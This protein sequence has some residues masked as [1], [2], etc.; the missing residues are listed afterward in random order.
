MR[1]LPARPGELFL[2]LYRERDFVRE[3][4]REIPILGRI[5]AGAPL[6]AVGWAMRSQAAQVGQRAG[7]TYGEAFRHARFHPFV[8]GLLSSA[9]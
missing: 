6:L 8:E 5:A 3:R 2:E 7:F 4:W 1:H 9:A